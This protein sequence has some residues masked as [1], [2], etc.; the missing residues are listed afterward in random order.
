MV[1]PRRVRLV[2]TRTASPAQPRDQGL[3]AAHRTHGSYSRFANSVGYDRS[4]PRL[5][6]PQGHQHIWRAAARCAVRDE[7]VRVDAGWVWVSSPGVTDSLEGRPPVECL[8]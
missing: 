5:E 3:V 7:V 2:R 1:S 6:E 8:E 4:S